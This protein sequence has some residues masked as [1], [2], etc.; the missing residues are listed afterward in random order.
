M[1]KKVGELSLINEVFNYRQ[2][3]GKTTLN[4]NEKSEPK[5]IKKKKLMFVLVVVVFYEK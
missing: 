1:K 5:N 4:R 3:K 2:G